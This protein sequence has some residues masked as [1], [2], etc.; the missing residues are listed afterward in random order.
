[1]S[2]IS[3]LPNSTVADSKPFGSRTRSYACGICFGWDAADWAVTA[4]SG[5]LVAAAAL[6]IVIRWYIR[7]VARWYIS[8]ISSD[9]DES[10]GMGRGFEQYKKI[11]LEVVLGLSSINIGESEMTGQSCG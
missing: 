2:C 3:L 4:I 7:Q 1:M 10:L 6:A 5:F 9:E 8:S 11:S